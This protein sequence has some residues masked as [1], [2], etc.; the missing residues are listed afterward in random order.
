MERSA[1]AFR[2]RRLTTLALALASVT[3]PAGMETAARATAPAVHAS[4]VGGTASVAFPAAGALLAGVDVSNAV[5]WCSGVLIGCNT[6]LTAAHCVCPGTGASCQGGRAPNPDDRVVY[7]QHAGF[8]RVASIAVHPS[9]DFPTA[10]LAVLRLATGVTGIPPAALAD[11]APAPGTTGSLVGFGRTTGTGADFGIKRLGTLA[12]DAC[13]TM[14]DATEVCWTYTGA[15]VDS[16]DGDSGGPLFVDGPTGPQVAGITSGGR[17]ARCGPGDVA[18][19]ANVHTYRE[20]IAA[21]A[22]ADLGGARCGGIPQV[23][24]ADTR[25]IAETSTISD[26][27]PVRRHAIDVPP[28]TNELR[29]ALNGVDDGQTNFDLAVRAGAEPTAT[30]ADC[31]GTGYGQYAYC[32]FTF[33]APGRWYVDVTRVTGSGTYQLTTTLVGGPAPVCGNGIRESGE[34]CDGDDDAA[35]PGGCG[36]DCTC[37]NPCT[38]GGLVPLRAALGPR[39]WLKTTIR[40]DGAWDGLDPRASDL[41]LTVRNDTAPLDV[42]IPAGDPGWSRSTSD[43]GVFRWS[44]DTADAHAVVLRCRRLKSGDW[45]VSLTGKPGPAPARRR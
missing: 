41:S 11:E 32:G 21:V 40:N 31:R 42:L 23:G 15:G 33:P 16:C 38:E 28:G 29:I 39:L 5:S 45:A 30:A 25:V 2:R 14:S 7:L 10:D 13:R 37:T 27:T 8:V 22:G 35:C 34:A 18:F 6:F 26:A 12:T 44:G 3:L 19:D 9:Y 1:P 17:D 20:W 4:V 43:D 24:D 36:T